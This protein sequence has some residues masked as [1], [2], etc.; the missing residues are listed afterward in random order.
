MPER[1]LSFYWF[2]RFGVCVYI[3]MSITY[4]LCIYNT[5]IYIYTYN[6]H[7]TYLVAEMGTNVGRLCCCVGECVCVRCAYACERTLQRKWI[8]TTRVLSVCATA[9]VRITCAEGVMAVRPLY[10]CA[11]TA[12]PAPTGNRRQ[13]Y[14][15][16]TTVYTPYGKTFDEERPMTSNDARTFKGY[17][18]SYVW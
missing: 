9:A 10:I 8:P 11:R 7:Y 13:Y 4:S 1:S 2:K 16:T 12:H 5:L 18:I 14:A 17:R 15:T 6:I 3:C